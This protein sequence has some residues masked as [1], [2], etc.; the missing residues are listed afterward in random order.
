MAGTTAHRRSVPGPDAAAALAGV[1]EGR[2]NI[3]EVVGVD[4]GVT[5]GWCGCS[6]EPGRKHCVSCG[7]DLFYDYASSSGVSAILV[8]AKITA[9][10]V[11]A[12]AVIALAIV[13]AV[14]TMPA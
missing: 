5:C 9:A 4:V 8:V 2:D 7:S 13:V 1:G 12:V 3:H 11:L 10:V 6:N 14:V